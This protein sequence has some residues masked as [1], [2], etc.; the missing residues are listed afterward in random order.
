MQRSVVKSKSIILI[1]P[2]LHLAWLALLSGEYIACD[3]SRVEPGQTQWHVGYVLSYSKSLRFKHRAPIFRGNTKERKDKIE[4]SRRDETFTLGNLFISE[5]S[6]RTAP[7]GTGDGLKYRGVEGESLAL[8]C[9]A[10]GFPAPIT[11]YTHFRIDFFL[12]RT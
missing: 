7:K 1:V 11:R 8:A 10:Q 5:P 6:G 4:T 9:A 3:D 2:V 12:I